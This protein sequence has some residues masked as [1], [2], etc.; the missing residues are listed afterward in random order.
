[1]DLRTLL[2]ATAPA[3]IGSALGTAQAALGAAVAQRNAAQRRWKDA[4]LGDD[5]G[6]SIA[7]RA[8]LG[9]AGV[10]VERAEAVVER[11][12]GRLSGGAF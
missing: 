5:L 11:L 8:A 6:E 3:A 2:S 12:T 7:A 4:L 9:A 10:D 1:M